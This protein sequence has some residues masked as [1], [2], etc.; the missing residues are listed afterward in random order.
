M[1]SHSSL[2]VIS[3]VEEKAPLVTNNA[4]T[5]FSVQE[6]CDSV[7][8]RRVGTSSA[9]FF[10]SKLSQ[11]LSPI[12]PA[13][14]IDL[15]LR[16]EEHHIERAFHFLAYDMTFRYDCESKWP[17]RVKELCASINTVHNNAGEQKGTGVAAVN[18]VRS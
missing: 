12:T 7:R 2:F 4:P 13:I 8:K 9:I 17:D 14:L 18:N 15:I 11:S 6:G 10:R 1:F 16:R 3:V 5:V